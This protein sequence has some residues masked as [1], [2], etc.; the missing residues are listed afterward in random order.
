MSALNID[1]DHLY[2]DIAL[3]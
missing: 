2:W 1:V 3:D